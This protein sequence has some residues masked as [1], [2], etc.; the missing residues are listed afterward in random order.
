MFTTAFLNLIMYYFEGPIPWVSQFLTQLFQDIIDAYVVDL[1]ASTNVGAD[2]TS[3]LSR[4]KAI[5][6]GFNKYWEI[7]TTWYLWEIDYWEM[8]RLFWLIYECGSMIH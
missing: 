3:A 2:V 6:A 1:Q 4:F 5:Q 7:D 8:T